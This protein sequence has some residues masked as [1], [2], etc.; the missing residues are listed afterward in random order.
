METYLVDSVQN[1]DFAI[2]R[3]L[4]DVHKTRSCQQL[5]LDLKNN[6]NNTRRIIQTGLPRCLDSIGIS[7]EPDESALYEDYLAQLS[8][9][10]INE[11]IAE[12]TAIVKTEPFEDRTPLRKLAALVPS[13]IILGLMLS[14]R[15]NI[16]PLSGIAI[17]GIGGAIFWY[18][19]NVANA[20]NQDETE[21]TTA[22]SKST[23]EEEPEKPKE[24]ITGPFVRL[25][26]KKFSQLSDIANQ[27]IPQCRDPADGI[28]TVTQS[29]DR[30]M[31]RRTEFPWDIAAK[32]NFPVYSKNN[33][34][35]SKGKGVKLYS[36]KEK[37]TDNIRDVIAGSKAC[38]AAAVTN[39]LSVDRVLGSMYS[40][41]DANPPFTVDS[42]R[43]IKPGSITNEDIAQHRNRTRATIT[44]KSANDATFT[45]DITVLIPDWLT[46]SGSMNNNPFD[47]KNIVAGLLWEPPNNTPP[48]FF[49]EQ[50]CI[51]IVLTVHIDRDVTKFMPMFW[52]YQEV[53]WS[54]MEHGNNIVTTTPWL[55][56]AA[57]K[58]HKAYGKR[59]LEDGAVDNEIY[60]VKAWPVSRSRTL[61]ETQ[62]IMEPDLPDTLT[63]GQCLGMSLMLV[64]GLGVMTALK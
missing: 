14:S 33:P 50:R 37:G 2:I 1:A 54:R 56:E 7:A 27:T 29:K 15:K 22:S 18:T 53:E 23:E 12:N 60:D 55:K 26:M 59:H 11:K 58:S 19:S 6:P 47:E 20:Q 25:N 35:Y 13:L 63:S 62:S 44:L 3:G 31:Y 34:M 49:L 52:D 36:Y 51:C 21:K 41:G 10:D 30:G 43:L 46:S 39:Y 5:N 45:K 17:M 38:A 24:S 40:D 42:I 8:V 57:E 32:L 48:E 61:Q 64:G 28:T 16:H 9:N 4:V